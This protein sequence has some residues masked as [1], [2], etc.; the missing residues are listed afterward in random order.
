MK[1][2]ARSYKDLDFLVQGGTIFPKKFMIFV[3]SI[4]E[5]EAIAKYLCSR[6]NK[7][8]QNDIIWYYSMMSD[9]FQEREAIALTIGKRRGATGT[10]SFGMVSG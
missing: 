3:D 2:S 10:D 7:E 4:K 9:E 8:N 1:F 5:S 6:L